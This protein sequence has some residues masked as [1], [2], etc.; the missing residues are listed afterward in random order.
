[1]ITKRNEWEKE[2]SGR[3]ITY[4]NGSFCQYPALRESDIPEIS[5]ELTIT[6]NGDES[7]QYA[8]LH[9]ETKRRNHQLDCLEVVL[10]RNRTYIAYTDHCS[11]VSRRNIGRTIR[12]MP[13]LSPLTKEFPETERVV[14]RIL[15]G[16][17]KKT[18]PRRHK[19][20]SSQ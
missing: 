11:K 16:L 5:F 10:D 19:T 1:M 2:E 4:H 12:V 18:K 6:D 7:D 13:L 15:S 9:F 14:D 17:V 8:R 3:D 20:H